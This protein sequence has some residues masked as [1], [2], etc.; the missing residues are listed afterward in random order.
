MSTYGHLTIACHFCPCGSLPHDR[1]SII[2]VVHVVYIV[3]CAS[4]WLAN[5]EV[6]EATLPT[7]SDPISF[8]Y[9]QQI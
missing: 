8:H 5:R 2:T 7:I 4:V 1:F 6:S 3:L 9:I